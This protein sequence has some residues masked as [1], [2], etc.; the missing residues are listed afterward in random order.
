MQLVWPRTAGFPKG[1][2]DCTRLTSV[3]LVNSPGSMGLGSVDDLVPFKSLPGEF[4]RMSALR[5]L[6]IRFCDVREFVGI[7]RLTSLESLQ[8]LDAL[9]TECRKTVVMFGC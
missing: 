9:S 1:L 8:V 6:R 5:Q 4:S 7:H 2:L 3:R